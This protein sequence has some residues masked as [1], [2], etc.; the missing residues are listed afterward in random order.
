MVFDKRNKTISHY[1]TPFGEMGLEIDTKSFYVKENEDLIQVE[2]A[3]SLGAEGAHM[4]DCRI[5]IQIMAATN[6]GGL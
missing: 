2:I 5:K 1:K 6:K 4:A 3:Y